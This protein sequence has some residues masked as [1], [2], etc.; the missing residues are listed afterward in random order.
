MLFVLRHP[1]VYVLQERCTAL[2]QQSPE[3]RQSRT[4]H[5]QAD[6]GVVIVPLFGRPGQVVF[7]RAEDVAS[8]RAEML[9]CGRL[10]TTGRVTASQRTD[11]TI[12]EETDGPA[13]GQL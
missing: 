10:R 8:R 1:A 5:A 6:D 11:G 13:V 7:Q 2:S 3:Q 9:Y 12:L 4:I